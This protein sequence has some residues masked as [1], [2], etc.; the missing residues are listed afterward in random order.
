[1]NNDPRNFMMRPAYVALIL[2][3]CVSPTLARA[4]TMVASSLEWLTCEAEVVV[5]GRVERI[6]S[7]R[8]PGDVVYDDCTVAV[9]EIISGKLSSDRLV[10]CLRTLSAE[11]PARAW[12][13]SP[14]AMLLFLSRS[15]GH[16]SEKHL[17]GQ[18]VPTSQQF[19]LSVF[20]LAAPGQYALDVRFNVLR[21]RNAILATCRSTAARLADHLRRNPAGSVEAERVETPVSSPAWN[22]LYAGSACYL[23]APKFMPSG[24]P[25]KP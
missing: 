18:F 15:Q 8:G 10:L 12:L 16:G 2:S 1:M 13:R 6:V 11:S 19:P 25:K 21:D 9:A 3:T 22:A 23:K 4:E 17:D 5:V 20:D 14:D 7:T 24:L